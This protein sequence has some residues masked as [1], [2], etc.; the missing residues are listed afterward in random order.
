MGF[1]IEVAGRTNTD[2]SPAV[3]VTCRPLQRPPCPSVENCD[4]RGALFP[5]KPP[6]PVFPQPLDVHPTLTSRFR[7]ADTGIDYRE[8]SMGRKPLGLKILPLSD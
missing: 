5:I 1:P 3:E 6:A 4:G 7:F 8:R 2:A